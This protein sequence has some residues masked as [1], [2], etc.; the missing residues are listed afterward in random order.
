MDTTPERI[1]TVRAFARTWTRVTGVLSAGLL[2][3]PYSLTEVRVLFELATGDSGDGIDTVELRREL[4]LDPGYLSRMVGRFKTDRLVTT[5]PSRR[6]AR[7][8]VLRLTTSGREVF[9]E[10][11]RRAESDVRSLLESLRD[12]DQQRLVSAMTTVRDL[13]EDVPKPSAYVIRP[14]R[15]G[16]LGWVVHRHGVLY[17]EEF[18][19]DSSFEALV[20][21]IV[22]DYGRS[23]D[24]AREDAWIAE[25]EGQP[26]GCVFCVAKDSATAQLRIL[27]VDPRA[28]GLGIG[29]RLVNECIAFARRAGY[30][31]IVLWT[32]DVL[33]SARRIY[34]A[35]GFR[36][37]DEEPHRSFG[38]DLVG[39]HWELAL[40]PTAR[41]RV[42]T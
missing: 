38:H 41:R 28:R 6:D 2:D 25:V 12:E 21:Q 27:L 39:Q 20:A 22:A 35:A 13:V 36:L 29:R 1:A 31:R 37:V 5:E 33:G 7:R 16:D 24:P 42:E 26:A 10:L 4:G 30:K 8:Q 14:L 3:S 17:A 19:W 40:T 23:H 18:G 34:E 11:D 32:N 15:P 9:D